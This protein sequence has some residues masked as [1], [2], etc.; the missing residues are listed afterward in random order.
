MRV[1]V[2]QTR[3]KEP[4]GFRLI[5]LK[6]SRVHGQGHTHCDVVIDDRLKVKQMRQ[7]LSRFSLRLRRLR[8]RYSTLLRLGGLRWGGLRE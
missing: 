4:R 2:D 7:V 1:A 3:A 6:Q 5:K 8:I